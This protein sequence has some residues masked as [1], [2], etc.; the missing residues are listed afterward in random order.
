MPDNIKPKVNL[1]AGHKERLRK[2]LLSHA[3]SLE[4]YEILE[5]LLG[6]I[7]FRKDTKPLAKEL[8]IHFSNLR[9][10]FDTRFDELE[11][12]AGTK[13]GIVVAITLF[14]ELMSRYAEAP[15]RQKHELANPE[16]VAQMAK[17][18]MGNLEH[19][20]CWIALV[21]A[22]N[23]LISWEL[24]LRGS[25]SDVQITPKDIFELA[26][27]HKCSGFILVHNHP[28]GSLKPSAPDIA[29][30]NDLKK[31]SKMIGIRFLDHIII[32]NNNC[33]SFIKNGIL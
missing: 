17:V 10:L 24:I 14:R 13:K 20:E 1:N 23:K 19:E 21:D 6:Y 5:I 29:L 33:F 3:Q 2:R 30:T 27:K 12:F 9:G 31:L 7:Y 22:Q 15:L 11:K 4:D 8:L 18:R 16:I 26:L 25:S 32:A 28:A